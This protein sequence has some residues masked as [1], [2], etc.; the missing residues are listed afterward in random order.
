MSAG[1]PQGSV[2]GLFLWIET[3]DDF[4]EIK[5]PEEATL[6]RFADDVAAVITAE[7]AGDL[8]IKANNSLNRAIFWMQNNGLKLAVL[9]TEAVLITDRRSFVPLQLELEGPRIEQ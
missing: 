5:V 2:L 4:L 3:Y 7:T 1:V 6:V 8:E 9:K